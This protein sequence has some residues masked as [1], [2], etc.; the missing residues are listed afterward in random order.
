MMFGAT[1]CTSLNSLSRVTAC[2]PTVF[3]CASPAAKTPESFIAST[4]MNVS[5]AAATL[6]ITNVVFVF[7]ELFPISFIML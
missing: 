1:I 2:P 6:F 4:L 3:A 7:P 5:T